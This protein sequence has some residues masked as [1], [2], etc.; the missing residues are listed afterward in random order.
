MYLWIIHQPYIRYTC[1]RLEISHNI[2][3]CLIPHCIH[4]QMGLTMYW[5]LQILL[6]PMVVDRVIASVC[7]LTSLMMRLW[8]AQSHSNYSL[9]QLI[10]AFNFLTSANKQLF[11]YMTVMVMLYHTLYSYSI[12]TITLKILFTFGVIL[13]LLYSHSIPCSDH[14]Q[15]TGIQQWCSWKCWRSAGLREYHLWHH[16]QYY[17]LHLLL[18]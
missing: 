18:N 10:Q 14:S 5:C 13:P 11:Q 16:W 4:G 3:T 1:L 9:L 2:H 15:T 17:C 8:R 12:L 6:F 7:S